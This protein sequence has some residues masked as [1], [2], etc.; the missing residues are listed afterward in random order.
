MFLILKRV[1]VRDTVKRTWRKE[2][3]KKWKKKNWMNWIV[4]PR[5]KSCKKMVKKKRKKKQNIFIKTV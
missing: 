3:K 1:C 2:M 4:F 5:S